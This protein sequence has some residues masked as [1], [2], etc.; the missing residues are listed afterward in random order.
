VSKLLETLAEELERPREVTGQVIEHIATYDVDRDDVGD[1]LE[2]KLPGLE[3]YEHDLILSPLFTPKL[4]DQALFAA[5]L[6]KE[7]VPR[8]Q[9]PELIQ[10]LAA[11]PTRGLL[12]TSDKQRH[13]V[14]LR[15]VVLERYVH[16]LRL[17]GSISESLLTLLDEEPFV[18]DRPLLQAIARRAI[19]ES[20]ARGEILTRYLTSAGRRNLYLP[21]DGV[22]LLR[23]AE[24]YKPADVGH[25]MERIPVWQEALRHEIDTAGSP[26]PFFS[27]AVQS[28][29]GGE[30]DQRQQDN[31]RLAAKKSE[32][33]FL[34]RLHQVL[35]G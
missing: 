16:R 10:Q 31:S 22:Q 29:H 4:P 26:K 30:R 9:W 13:V 18:S 23:I 5:L 33:A 7:S 14:L 34:D 1:F 21:G 25:L 28:E 27:G 15:E 2:T 24:D 35:V 20:P 32:F 8:S 12:I 11:R 3:D 6:G 19:W 17:D